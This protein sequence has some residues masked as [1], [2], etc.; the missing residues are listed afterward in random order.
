MKCIPWVL[1]GFLLTSF[2][3]WT[4]D[5]EGA[6]PRVPEATLISPSG[7]DF[8]LAEAFKGRPGLLFFYPGGWHPASVKILKD[9]RNEEPELTRSGC[10]IFALTP[11]LPKHILETLSDHALP[12]VV[13]HD[14]E[15]TVSR[16]FDLARP[17]EED[18]IKGMMRYGL[19]IRRRTG[20]TGVR[21]PDPAFLWVNGEGQVLKI[22]R[23]TSLEI[24]DM[25]GHILSRMRWLL[26][27]SLTE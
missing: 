10:R 18:E 7:E 5:R 19:D 11:D 23:I 4:D 26:S 13:L 21:L 16:Y 1:S 15:A 24:D 20:L 3:A 22:E 8:K 6:V 25:P 12:F 14:H 2:S 27:K 17:L 9:L